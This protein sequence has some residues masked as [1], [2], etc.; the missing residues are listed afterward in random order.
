MPAS[1]A[2]RL[3]IRA[4]MENWVLWRDAGDWERF[5]TLWHKGGT[6]ATTFFE[7]PY[8]KFIERSE[9][10]IRE[11]A[12]ITH[13]LG[14]TSVD[15]KGRRALAQSKTAIMQR[16]AVD[17]VLCDVVC[18]G[19]VYALI[20]KRGARWGIVHLRPIYEKDRLDPVDPS[21]T[22]KLD[23]ALLGQFPEGYRHLGYLQSK[24][25]FQVRTDRPGLSG[26]SLEALYAMGKAWLAG[27]K[28]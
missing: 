7:G 4:L 16:A 10:A 3:A 25:G 21:A 12:N 1:T 8:E 19:R 28:V 11:G 26:P 22:L 13:M 5:R 20:E 15:I 14:A 2:D 9:Q 17:D 18:H 23:P 27:K 6:M 24:T